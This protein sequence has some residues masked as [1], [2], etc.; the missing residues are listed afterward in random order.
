MP[1]AGII[2]RITLQNVQSLAELVGVSEF[3]VYRYAYR[4]HLHYRQFRLAKKCGGSR[5]ISAPVPA[6]K[7][8]QRRIAR[9]ILNVVELHDS[10]TG[11]RKGCSIVSNACVHANRDFVFNVDIKDFFGT[12]RSKRVRALF[13]GLGFEQRIAG[14]LTKL[15]TY[16]GV[17]PQGAPSS[18]VIGNL[19]CRLLDER[20]AAF[21]AAHEW[22]YTRYCDDI[23]ISGNGEFT[24]QADV[25]AIIES[26]GFTINTNKVRLAGKRSRQ[27]VT[28]LVVN[29]FAN[30]A[31]EQRRRMRAMFHNVSL[32]PAAYAGL[33]HKLQGCVGL[34]E[35]I[36]PD[37]PALPRYRAI[38]E[39]LSEA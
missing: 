28:G 15:C 16:H 2:G 4:A 18:P 19:V 36:R 23:T 10:A 35:M 34:L 30:M 13:V 1:R 25:F 24:A 33:K 27:M 29:R 17:L 32:D 3:E 37:D 14:F 22:T 6:L 12:I 11:Y 39:G 26:E 20:L 8:I 31:R 7:A 21:C 38:V 5:T 9:K